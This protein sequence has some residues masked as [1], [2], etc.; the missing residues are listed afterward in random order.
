MSSEW[1]C[2]Q[3]GELCEFAAGSAFKQEAQGLTRGDY[4]FVKVSDMNLPGNETTLTTANNFVTEEVRRQLK[5]KAH[6]VGATVFAKIGVALTTNRRRLL[7]RPTII[8]NN[9][10]A[11][12]PRSGVVTDRFLYYLLSTIDFN[13][14]AAGTA[15]P[16]LNVSDLRKIGVTVPNIEIQQAIAKTLASIDDSITLLRETNATL[17]AIAQALFKSW[18]VDFDPVRAKM[19][20]LIPEG[21]DE[22]TAALFP[23]SLEESELGLVPKGWG[24]AR[25]DSILELAYGKALKAESRQPGNVPVYGSGGITGWHETALVSRASIVV[26]RKGTV[27][28]LYWESRPFFPIDTVFF[29]KSDRP[30]SYCYELLK[31]LGLRDMNTDAAVPGLNRE[32]VYRLLTPSVPA[33]VIAAYDS[34]VGGIRMLIDHNSQRVETLASLRDTLLPRL[35]SGQLRLPEA[36]DAI[37]DALT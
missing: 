14:I 6:P 7:T 37:E 28:S 8:D 22:A 19:Q 2:T 21:M 10:M 23:D 25:L 24:I 1:R 4:P 35:I 9:M 33:D 5:A 36:S 26:G 32:N 12:I 17:E 27:G 3:L 16:Y 30:M 20:G 13:P 34:I 18:F 31:T 11:A 15:L 29:V